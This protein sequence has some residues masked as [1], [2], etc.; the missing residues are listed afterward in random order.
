VIPC[1]V[2]HENPAKIDINGTYKCCH[3]WLGRR[4]YMVYPK[5]IQDEKDTE[6]WEE[7]CKEV[8]E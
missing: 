1:H 8:K 2:C 7:I 5:G 3:C 4:F 6:I